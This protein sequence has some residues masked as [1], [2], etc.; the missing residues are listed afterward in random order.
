MEKKKSKNENKENIWFSFSKTSLSKKQMA[1]I[2][3]FFIN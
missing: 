2:P 3:M 1:M